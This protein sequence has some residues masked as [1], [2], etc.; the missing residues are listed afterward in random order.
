MGEGINWLLEEDPDGRVQE[1]PWTEPLAPS[2]SPLNGERRGRPGR[3][4]GDPSGP[5]SP[6]SHQGNHGAR[7]RPLQVIPHPAP[8]LLQ[9]ARPAPEPWEE[10]SPRRDGGGSRPSRP[11]PRS[12][13]RIR[14]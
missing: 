2:E 5:E 11:R 9:Q 13:R 1:A 7:R 12:S 4:A 3:T 6:W 10:E 14:P 8:P